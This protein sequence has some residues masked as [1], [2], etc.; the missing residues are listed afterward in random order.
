MFGKLKFLLSQPWPNKI[1]YAALFYY[2]I[3]TIL[4]YRMF[5]GNIGN[6]S[7]LRPPCFLANTQYIH[8]G[9]NSFIAAGARLECVITS[10]TRKPELR[11]G[12]NVNIEQ[13]AH[14]TCHNKIIIGPNVS[15]APMCTIMDTTHPVDGVACTKVGDLVVDDDACVEIGENSWIG[16]GSVI[17]PNVRIGRRCIVG[18]N[19]V[20]M[21]DIPDYAVVLG[22]PARVIRYLKGR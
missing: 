9:S 7:F 5:F 12:D 17:L 6:K 14:I 4:Y 20:V 15:I 1:N 16:V 13:N 22:N 10:P 8:I 11:I 18:A 2:R 21:S 19:S 3:K